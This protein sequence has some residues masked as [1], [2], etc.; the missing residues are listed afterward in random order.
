MY[1]RQDLSQWAKDAFEAGEDFFYA[2]PMSSETP[3]GELERC[4]YDC[5]YRNEATEKK[6]MKNVNYHAPKGTWL[7][8]PL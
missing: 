8:T 1:K 2:S 4:P 7:A 3:Y 5:E 6:L